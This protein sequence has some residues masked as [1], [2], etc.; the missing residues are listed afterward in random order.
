MV[1]SPAAVALG[2]PL[3]C[4]AR[5]ENGAWCPTLRTCGVQQFMHD[6]QVRNSLRY[7]SWKHHKAVAWDLKGV[8]GAF[9][10]APAKGALETCAKR[11]DPLTP[12]IS[13]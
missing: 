5:R 13:R 1:R 10:R 4:R 3:S 8:H 12:L 2:R 6:R 11:W 7:V 9:T